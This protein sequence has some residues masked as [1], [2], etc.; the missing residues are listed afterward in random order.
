MGK[1]SDFF[2]SFDIFGHPVGV[3]YKGEDTF[4][5][6]VG[7]FCTIAM[8]VLTVLSLTTLITAFVDNSK[9]ATSTQ[10]STYD[11]FFE[12]AFSF[13]ENHAEI[14]IWLTSAFGGLLT[15]DIG[16][17]SLYQVKGCTTPK[18]ATNQAACKETGRMIEVLP[19]ECSERKVDEM[20]T[21]YVP[22]YG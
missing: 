17:M 3:N 11:P 19:Q 22:R 8:Y 13:S 15:P 18:L 10:R 6:R 9:L 5:T 21:Y 4:K 14:L 16:K 20:E 2:T 1:F 12:P 7:A